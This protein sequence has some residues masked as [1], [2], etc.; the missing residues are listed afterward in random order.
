MQRKDSKFQLQA[1]SKDET[2]AKLYRPQ[3][4]QD[5]PGHQKLWELM[6]TYIGSDKRQI[7]RAIVNHVEYTLARTRFQFDNFGAYQAASL[8][9][10]DRLIEAWNDTNEFQTVSQLS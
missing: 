7:Q 5:Q 6:S 1:D 9:V 2:S 10:R 3:F 4:G 8:S